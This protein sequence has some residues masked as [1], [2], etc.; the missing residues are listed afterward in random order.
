MTWTQLSCLVFITST[1]TNRPTHFTSALYEDRLYITC[2]M[3][4][5]G[6]NTVVRP[7]LKL[8]L[9]R[10]RVRVIVVLLRGLLYCTIISFEEL[11][12]CH[13]TVSQ[14]VPLHPWVVLD[15]VA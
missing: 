11:A 2:P 5:Q 12:N 10:L 15:A 8:R 14:W 6:L 7:N 1:T 9:Y 3:A 4:G 13:I